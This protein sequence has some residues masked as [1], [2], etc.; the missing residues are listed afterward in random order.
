MIPCLV[1]AGTA[2]MEKAPV[3]VQRQG[4]ALETAALLGI[5]SSIPFDWYMRRWVE[6]KLSF[7][8]LNPSPIPD[9]DVTSSL[10][11]RL[12]QAAGS[13]AAVDGRY[14]DWA[15]E[16]GVPVG[17][18][19]AQL[20]KDDLIAELDALVSLLYGLSKDQVE[21]IFET[22]HRGWAYESRLEAVLKHYVAWKD[23]A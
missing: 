14:A 5:L 13:L 12:V 2:A 15:A 18:I 23:K 19:D 16:V 4:G 22:F 3:V 20:Q 7:E 17:S 1:P 9:V 10:G 8:L 11:S 6:M 21:H